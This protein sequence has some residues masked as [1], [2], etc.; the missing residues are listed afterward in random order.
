MFRKRSILDRRSEN[1]RRQVYNLDYFRQGGIE[2]RTGVERREQR[3][4]RRSG[5]VNV[6]G[7][8]S[9]PGDI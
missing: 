7:W 4:E 1:D 5:W 9:V 3:Q 6:N 8:S 2:R